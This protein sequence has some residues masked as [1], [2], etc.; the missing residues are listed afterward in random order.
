MGGERGLGRKVQQNLKITPDAQAMLSILSLATG[1]TMGEVV[2]IA[3]YEYATSHVNEIRE[4]LRKA[5]EDALGTFDRL[6]SGG[7]VNVY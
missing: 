1:K 4:H 5:S 6:L 2:E 3:L 7:D